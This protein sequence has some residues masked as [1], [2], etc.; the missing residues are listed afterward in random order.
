MSYKTSLTSTTAQSATGLVFNYTYDD[1]LAPTVTANLNAARV[2]AFYLINTV[3]DLAYRYGFTEAS[4]N[5][6]VDNG[7]KGG[8]GSD[9][10]RISVQDSSG[11]NNANFATPAEYVP[12]HPADKTEPDTHT[13]RSTRTVPHVR[14]DLHHCAHSLP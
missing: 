14:L 6:Q 5:F 4:Y 2:N 1:T 9:P 3:H 7:S 8:K 12:I 13:Q 10:V 11:T